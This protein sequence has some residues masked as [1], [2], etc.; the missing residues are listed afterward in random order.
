MLANTVINRNIKINYAL[1]SKSNNM[2]LNNKTKRMEDDK[3]YDDVVEKNISTSDDGRESKTHK[4][5]INKEM[6]K[7]NS[8]VLKK[9]NKFNIL[10]VN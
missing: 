2:L 1:S 10:L 7:N 9:K 6:T 5:L 3:S 4:I 8:L